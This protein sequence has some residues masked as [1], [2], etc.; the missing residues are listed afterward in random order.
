MILRAFNWF[1]VHF[2]GEF[3][4]FFVPFRNTRKCTPM[5]AS[6]R[7]CTPLH[8]NARQCTQM[9]SMHANERGF[10]PSPMFFLGSLSRAWTFHL[11]TWFLLC[12]IRRWFY[13]F[14]VLVLVVL[15]LSNSMYFWFE[16]NTLKILNLFYIRLSFGSLS[17]TCATPI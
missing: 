15:S 7:K 6:A 14:G 3:K 9:R 1:C 13:G 17:A 2:R 11:S 4:C 10:R 16:L 5:N 12:T 8:A